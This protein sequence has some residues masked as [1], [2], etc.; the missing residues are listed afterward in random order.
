MQIL[1][2]FESRT[3]LFNSIR[4]ATAILKTCSNFS[5]MFAV[6]L[7]IISASPHACVCDGKPTQQMPIACIGPGKIV[8]ALRF[9]NYKLS[10]LTVKKISV[11]VLHG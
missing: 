9:Q 7:P 2:N 3:G 10:Y 8:I 6:A 1:K 5:N 4:N 11:C